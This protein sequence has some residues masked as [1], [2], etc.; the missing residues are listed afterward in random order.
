MTFTFPKSGCLLGYSKDKHEI[1]FDNIID[2]SKP[3]Y[4]IKNF[5]PREESFLQNTCD[6]KFT[7]EKGFMGSTAMV[8][9]RDKRVSLDLEYAKELLEKYFE[10]EMWSQFQEYIP[11]FNKK[12]AFRRF[13]ELLSEMVDSFD[14]KAWLKE[15]NYIEN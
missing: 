12:K 4:F 7:T 5:Y 6:L 2:P 1:Y 15:F 8:N 10:D 13:I 3:H 14:Y 11:E 9:F